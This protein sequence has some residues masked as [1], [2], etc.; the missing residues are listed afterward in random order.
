MLNRTADNVARA[1]PEP[2]ARKVRGISDKGLAW[3]FISPTILLLLAINIFPLFWA[4]YLSFTNYRANRSNEVVKNLGFANYQRILGDQDVWIAMQTT[5]HFVFWTILLQTVIG[6]TLA[7]LIDRKFRGHAFWT[8]VILVPMM[9]SPAVVGNFWRFLYQPQTGLF[10]YLVAFFTGVPPS[11]FEMLGSV[12]LAP[13]AIII[14]DT[15]M[16]TPYVMLICLAGLRSIPE[17]IYEA[18]E[19]DRAS[20]W[21]QFWSITLPMALPFIMLAVLFRGIENFK[22]FDMVNLLTG[23]GPGSTTEVASITLKRQAFESWRTG[24]SSAFAIILFVAVFGLANIYVKALNKV[25]QR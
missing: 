6:F 1:T 12:Q 11:S 17:Y 9:L 21:R 4:I 10:N 5:A 25:K 20:N 7:W 15:W 3:L 22:M 19:V 13:W 23:G 8:T 16:W 24:Y 18:A 2:L 14:V